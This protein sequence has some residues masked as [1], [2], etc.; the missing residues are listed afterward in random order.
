V[1]DARHIGDFII[2][3]HSTEALRTSIKYPHCWM[4]LE[5]TVHMNGLR[6]TVRAS[7]M[8]LFNDGQS[9]FMQHGNHG[10]NRGRWLP[11]ILGAHTTGGVSNARL[12]INYLRSKGG[13][14]GSRWSLMGGRQGGSRHMQPVVECHKV[15]HP[16]GNP[17]CI[18]IIPFFPDR[19]M[20]ALK[21]KGY[22]YWYSLFSLIYWSPLFSL[23]YWSPLFVKGQ[24]NT[25]IRDFY[26]TRSRGIHT[27]WAQT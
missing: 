5:M 1:C 22:I 20:P 11:E 23:I 6:I 18:T 3:G 25:A 9:V 14:Q 27:R 16:P 26:L 13:N 21:S 4:S 8:V 17:A 24:G 10:R 7:L 12:G 15:E 19:S 2:G